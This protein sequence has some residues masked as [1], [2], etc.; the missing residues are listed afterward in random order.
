MFIY[1]HYYQWIVHDL[2]SGPPPPNGR[3]AAPEL[4]LLDDLRPG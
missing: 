1:A 2:L 3:P 4:T